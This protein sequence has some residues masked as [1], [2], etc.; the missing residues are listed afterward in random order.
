[1][2]EAHSIF[3]INEQALEA[4]WNAGGDILRFW[5]LAI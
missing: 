5:A 4:I 3:N 2:E 1:L